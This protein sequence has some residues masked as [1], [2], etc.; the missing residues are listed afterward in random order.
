L[1]DYKRVGSEK[2]IARPPV[3]ANMMNSSQC[4]KT[5]A[6]RR[7]VDKKGET[8]EPGITPW[9]GR[10]VRSFVIVRADEAE[11]GENS[12]EIRLH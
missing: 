7:N 2:M 3:P 5:T 11:F 8:P 4:L 1:P 12:R 9:L 10:A 6:F